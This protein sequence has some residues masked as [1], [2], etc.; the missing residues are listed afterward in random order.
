[1]DL[2]CEHTGAD[3]HSYSN[4][5]WGNSYSHGYGDGNANDNDPD[6]N[7]DGDRDRSDSDGNAKRTAD[8]AGC[9]DAGTEQRQSHRSEPER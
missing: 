7:R 5:Y 1:L 4:R 6:G 3:S 8:G 2:Y 9:F